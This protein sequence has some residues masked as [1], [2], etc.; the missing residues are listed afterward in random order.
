MLDFSVYDT[1]MAAAASAGLKV[2][3]VVMDPPAWRSTAPATGALRAMYPPRDVAAMAAL[4]TALVQ[5]Y[6]P[7]GSFWA[8]HPELSPV[9]DP[10][11]AGVERA[12]HPGV[13]G[14]RARTP[15]PTC[16]CS[17]RSGLRSTPPTRTPRS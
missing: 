5:R 13:L 11:L 15:P 17:A 6:G 8:S 14:D 4:T 10:Q 1:V 9:A 2:L 12:E 16:A 7:G 3:P